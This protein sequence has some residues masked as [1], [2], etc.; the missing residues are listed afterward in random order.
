MFNVFG[1]IS[2]ISSGLFQYSQSDGQMDFDWLPVTGSADESHNSCVKKNKNVG[3]MIHKKRAKKV[4]TNKT[5]K[6][7]NNLKISDTK[8]RFLEL[9]RDQPD[10]RMSVKVQPPPLSRPVTYGYACTGMGVCRMAAVSL[11]G[12]DGVRFIFECEKDPLALK[13]MKAKGMT[14]DHFYED[15]TS[16]EF[17]RLAPQVEVFVCGF[18]CQPWSSA[19][20]RWGIDDPKGRGI[21]VLHLLRYIRDRQPRVVVLENVRGLVTHHMSSL[22]GIVQVLR[23]IQDSLTHVPAYSVHVEVLDSKKCGLV[24]HHRERVYIVALKRC[25]RSHVPFEFPDEVCCPPL[26]SVVDGDRIPLSSYEGYPLPVGR[27]GCTT[28]YNRVQETLD[29]V[30]R[31]AASEGCTPESYEVA[32]DAGSSRTNFGYGVCP[33][34]TKTRGSSLAMFNLQMGDFFNVKEMLRLQGFADE[35]INA[36]NLHCVTARQL[37]GLIGHSFTKTVVQRILKNAIRAAE[38]EV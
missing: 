21:V 18:P 9:K 12:Y 5:K 31:R 7:Q 29:A 14:S 16:D 25:G 23:D 19:G 10:V 35:E 15:A 11:H 2:E 32:V 26:S 34:I 24:P 17:Y 22:E 20:L 33:C 36:L 30:R 3:R 37:G 6:D 28:S 13:I 38:Q 1:L 8:R 27:G 4:G